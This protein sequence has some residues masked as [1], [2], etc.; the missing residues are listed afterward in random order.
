MS[1]TPT[2]NELWRRV[3]VAVTYVFAY[4]LQRSTRLVDFTE[5]A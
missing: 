1:P 5:K 4:P 2:C 3:T